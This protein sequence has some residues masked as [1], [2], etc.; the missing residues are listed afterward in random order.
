MEGFKKYEYFDHT[1][2]ARYERNTPLRIF[3]G[4]LL[5]VLAGVGNALGVFHVSGL[6]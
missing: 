2:L 6:G 5:L 4:I 1:F 3:V